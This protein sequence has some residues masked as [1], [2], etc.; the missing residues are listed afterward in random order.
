MP[1]SQPRRS[2]VEEQAEIPEHSCRRLWWNCKRKME[3]KETTWRSFWSLWF[4][5]RKKADQ[6]T[7]WQV[8]FPQ[9]LQITD[10]LWLTAVTLQ[11]SLILPTNRYIMSDD[12]AAILF[13]YLP[14]KNKIFKINFSLYVFPVQFKVIQVKQSPRCNVFRFSW[15]HLSKSCITWRSMATMLFPPHTFARSLYWYCRTRKVGTFVPRRSFPHSS[16]RLCE[17][18][19]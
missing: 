4:V 7:C 8:Y 9:A 16:T 3:A 15:Q 6:Q 11:I 14:E 1:N 13:S 2:V 17:I 19:P 12:R 18:A 5:M 10:H